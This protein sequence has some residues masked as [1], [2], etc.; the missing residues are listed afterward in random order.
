MLA[1]KLTQALRRKG[2]TMM[3]LSRRSGVP[4]DTVFN[5]LHGRRRHPHFQL[6]GRLARALDVSL[7]TLLDDDEEDDHAA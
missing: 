7:D 3:E 4:Y 5:V 2:W 6:V 1:D